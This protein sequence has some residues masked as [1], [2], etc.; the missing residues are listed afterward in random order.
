MIAVDARR[1]HVL[2]GRS[3]ARRERQ[4]RH[5]SSASLHGLAQLGSGRG[6]GPGV[7]ASAVRRLALAA[8]GARRAGRLRAGGRPRRRPARRLY[9][10]VASRSGSTSTSCSPARA[11][12]TRRRSC[13]CTS[14]RT[15]SLTI[16]P[17]AMDRVSRRWRPEPDRRPERPVD[18]AGPA[19][20]RARLTEPPDPSL[21]GRGQPVSGCRRPDGGRRPTPGEHEQREPSA[22]SRTVTA[23]RGTLWP[24]TRPRPP[25]VVTRLPTAGA[26]RLELLVQRVLVLEAAHQPAAGPGDAQRVERQILVLGHPDG[27]RLEVGEEGGAAQVAPARADPAL[28]PGRV[29]GGQ[30]AQLDPAVQGGAEVADQRPEVDPVRRGEVDRGAAAGTGVRL[31][32][33][34]VD[35]DHLHRQLVLADQ[36]LGGDLR[37]RLA[38]AE[39]LVPAQVLVGRPGRPAGGSRRCPR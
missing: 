38:P 9:L 10:L 25:G 2:R 27:H 28:D 36:P 4:P 3:G 6:A 8:A 20:S 26:R 17:I 29:A 32:E 15:V 5:S 16:Y 11:S 12:R 21:T 33:H 7:A 35:G 13:A 30:L 34:V 24:T 22:S 19:R 31:A 18:R 1:R 14:T 23:S 37:L 39:Q